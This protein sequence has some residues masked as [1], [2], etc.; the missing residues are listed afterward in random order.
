MGVFVM[1]CEFCN[2]FEFSSVVIKDN[3]IHFAGGSNRFTDGTWD[4]SVYKL[5]Q[6]CPLCGAR[7]LY[8]NSP[9][10]EILS[11]VDRVACDEHG[12]RIDY[13]LY[14]TDTVVDEKGYEVICQLK[15]DTG[16]SFQMCKNAYDYAIAHK[17]DYSMMIAYCK[18]KV[19]AVE[20]RIPFDAR[21]QEFMKDVKDIKVNS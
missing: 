16:C 6:Y 9:A 15:T 20:A 4:N 13:A 11:E 21:V 7:L 10:P 8:K 17:G 1:S 12:N 3:N 14:E 5:F 18:A 2:K 19:V